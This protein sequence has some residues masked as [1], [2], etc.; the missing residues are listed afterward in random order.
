MFVVIKGSNK[1]HLS[2]NKSGNEFI[3]GICKEQSIDTG[4]GGGSSHF[5]EILAS[6]GRIYC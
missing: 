3:K 4:G 5:C 2:F 1:C 6:R